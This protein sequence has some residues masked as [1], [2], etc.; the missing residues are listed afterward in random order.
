MTTFHDSELGDI[1]VRRSA[2]AG[3][4]RIRMG[5]DGRFVVSTGQLTPLFV[6]KQTVRSARAKLAKL[7][8]ANPVRS[9]R[10]GDQIGQ[11]HH[12]VVSPGTQLTTRIL[13]RTLQLRLPPA[14][15]I[16]DREVQ[17]EVRQ[18]VIKLLRKE[19]KI[20]LTARLR[21][22]ATRHEFHYTN[23]RFAHAATRW[24]SC[25]SR[26]TISLNIALMSLTLE[27]IDYVLIHE[28]CHTRHMDHSSRFWDEVAAID[29]RYK[30]HRRQ[31]KTKSPHI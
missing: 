23:I 11:S 7:R 29:P 24:G 16:D 20:Y 13:D 10:D 27:Q 8:D 18:A 2:R 28:L 5:T 30:L 15:S 12:L 26:G 6:I 4:I 3:G 22:L 25:S 31:L 21:I 9:Y 19:A 14:M 17:S 1:V